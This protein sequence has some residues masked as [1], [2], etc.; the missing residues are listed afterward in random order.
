MNPM[1]TLRI[2]PV[3]ILALSLA[4]IWAAACDG[5][6]CDTD[7]FREAPFPVE[8]VDKT[9][10][11]SGEVRL[12][13]HG[14]NFMV[15]EIDNLIGA[16]AGDGE[17]LSF[18][19]PPSE[20]D[21]F[22]LCHEDAVCDDG[23]PGCQLDLTIEDASID[24]QAPNRLVID[25]TIGDLHESLPVSAVVPLFGNTIHCW[26][27]VYSMSGGTDVP[28]E[29]PAQIIVDFEI[30]E[31]SPFQDVW[32][33]IVDLEANVDGVDFRLRNRSGSGCGTADF[34]IGLIG[35][36]SMLTDMIEEQLD[37][38]VDDLTRGQ[39]CQTCEDGDSPCPNNATCDGGDPAVCVYNGSDQ[40][41]P[42]LLGIEGVI[43]PEGLLGEMLSGAAADVFMT[44]R[45]ADRAVADTGVTLGLRV[46]SEPEE[47]TNCAPVDPTQ[48]PSFAAIDPSPSINQ[49]VTPEGN[50]F[51]F[52]LALHRRTF[53]HLMWSL[54]ASGALCLEIGGE[55]LDLLNTGT[56]GALVPAIQDVA[57]QTS[58]MLLL[59]SPQEAPD[60]VLGA[61]LVSGSNVDEGLLT[62]DWRDLDIHMYAFVMERYARLFTLRVDVELPIAVVAEEGGLVPVLGDVADAIGN[63]R[64]LND[65]LIDA[66]VSL[67]EDL[68]PTLLGFALP[69]LLD[70]LSDPIELPEIFG[71]R[72]VI[73]DGDLR[74]IDNDQYLGLFANLEFVGFDLEEMILSTRTLIREDGVRI[75]RE[76]RLPKVAVD[77]EVD[78]LRGDQWLSGEEVE[79]L[80]RLNRGAWRAAGTGPALVIEDP[81][82]A[83]QG[84]Y[85]LELLGRLPGETRY[86]APS[87]VVELRVDY[88]APRVSAWAEDT[89]VRVEAEDLVDPVEALQMRHR[90]VV[91]DD[92][93]AWSRWEPVADLELL[94][95]PAERFDVE[96]EVRDQ[97]GHTA[98]EIVAVRTQALDADG[99]PV[100]PVASG[101]CA[102]SA[103]GGQPLGMLL[104]LVAAGL[105]WMRRRRSS[106]R[107]A[108]VL[109]V[110]LVALTGCRG[111]DPPGEVTCP[112]ECSDFQTCEDGVCV[113]VGCESDSECEAGICEGGA[114][115][116]G[117]RSRSDCD[118]ECGSTEYVSCQSSSC[119]CLPFCPEGCGE[120]QYCCYTSN[121]CRNF[122]NACSGVTC[123]DGFEPSVTHVGEADNE[124]CTVSGAICDCVEM[125]PLPLLYHGLYAGIAEGGG[126]VATSVHNMG[127][128]DLMVGILDSNFEPEW[129]FVDGVPESGSIT[130]SLDGP[131]G[132]IS[133]PGPRAGTH[134]SIAVGDDGTIHVFYRHESQNALKY[135][136]LTESGGTWDHE[137]TVV[138]SGDG[139]SGFYTA[140][141]LHDDTLHVF[142]TT[143]LEDGLSELRHRAIG[144]DAALSSFAESSIDVLH[145]GTREVEGRE[146]YRP[147]AAFNTRVRTIDDGWLVYF[148]DNTVRQPCWLTFD[149]T[150]FSSV[151]LLGEV[152]GPYA[153]VVIDGDGD[154]HWA[155]MDPDAPRLL[156]RDP[157]GST[158]VIDSGVRHTLTCTVRAPIGHDVH[159]EL[160]DE[161][162]VF[163]HDATTHE[164]VQ[165]VLDGSWQLEAIAGEAGQVS[166]GHGFFVRT[167]ELS[168]GRRL[169]VDFFIDTTGEEQFGQPAFRVVD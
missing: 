82:M 167:L 43:E 145:S 38:L 105:F 63:M 49:D 74:A 41:V 12:T 137:T 160:G 122:P 2:G 153:S 78:L 88:E 135:A 76:G 9:V 59:L 29:I 4:L 149:G 33:N 60:V 51:M 136:R 57:P 132:G 27:D 37:E 22:S 124:E 42:M 10:P 35:L 83:L 101:G 30:D 151:S 100:A 6:G 70:S 121:S 18:C 28:A 47:F 25:V 23:S 91:G 111:D 154:A 77:L 150:D 11:V 133:T 155:Y 54:W 156:Y 14:L 108:A 67:L 134:T 140:T 112:D 123:E 69:E 161:L 144:A 71:Y 26:I 32:I 75:D 95:R 129:Y 85:E 117:C 65:E 115:V 61:N 99:E 15:G 148:F 13:S 139:S 8:H 110:A 44:A 50:P 72:I 131:R 138:E 40:C 120:E 159:L 107:A 7:G 98:T 17:G 20:G 5:G 79:F 168:D 34:L 147:V 87:G 169:V 48:R 166:A 96:L 157:S 103:T 1:K 128:G 3:Q 158:S 109:L 114:C 130:G 86:T 143:R 106:G 125:P 93:G 56:L 39:L 104:V 16:L 119:V 21:D 55:D 45:V 64:V 89:L 58:P 80:Y 116:E 142:Y 102:C 31:F 94:E 162:E 164:L 68:L 66:D 81:A 141:V 127:Y 46:G 52:G 36:R 146:E 126:V 62:V 90:L 97:S 24:P 73:G 19:I 113:D 165:G 152:T 163:F 92:L 118:I 53:Q 84:I